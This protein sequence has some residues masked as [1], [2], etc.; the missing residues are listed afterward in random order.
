MK[1]IIIENWEIQKQYRD[2]VI[3]ETDEKTKI[4]YYHATFKTLKEALQYITDRL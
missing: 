4:I 3:Y 1:T 2:Y